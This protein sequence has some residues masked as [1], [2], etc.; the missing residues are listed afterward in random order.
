MFIIVGIINLKK[1]KIIK[2]PDDSRCSICSNFLVTD[3]LQIL[4]D[5]KEGDIVFITNRRKGSKQKIYTILEIKEDM[6]AIK[7]EENKVEFITWLSL[8]EDCW[9]C[10]FDENKSIF[11]Q[12]KRKK[13]NVTENIKLLRKLKLDKLKE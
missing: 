8:A 1:E 11:N 7:N 12:W 6:V 5:K 9:D 3:E 2:F 4:L 13:V 10:L